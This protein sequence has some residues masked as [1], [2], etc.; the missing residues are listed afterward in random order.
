MK[1][2]IRHWAAQ[3]PWYGYNSILWNYWADELSR[4]TVLMETFFQIFRSKSFIYLLY[5]YVY[6]TNYYLY[7]TE[8]HSTSTDPL[9]IALML[10]SENVASADTNMP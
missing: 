5:I 3:K 1:T 10:T 2:S 7:K 9:A 6:Y 8:P 4:I